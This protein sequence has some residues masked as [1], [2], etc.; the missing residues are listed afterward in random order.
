[1]IKT[2]I[3]PSTSLTSTLLQHSHFKLQSRSLGVIIRSWWKNWIYSI[4][5]TFSTYLH[6]RTRCSF[7]KGP[8][9][10]DGRR[11]QIMLTN[12]WQ[13]DCKSSWFAVWDA[14]FSFTNPWLNQPSLLCEPFHQGGVAARPGLQYKTSQT[15][16]C[17][18]HG[19]L[20]SSETERATRQAHL[21]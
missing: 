19:V 5:H 7:A 21:P 18:S 9:Y 20:G 14:L 12:L 6:F 11:M 15:F 3:C 8:R 1:M 16:M 10:Q 17:K 4:F 13:E 2:P